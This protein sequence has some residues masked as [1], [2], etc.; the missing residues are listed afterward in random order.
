MKNSPEWLNSRSEQGEE[1]V[2]K[3]E[4][5]STE[6][7]Q[8]EEQNVKRIKTYEQRP[9]GQHKLYQYMH[10]GSSRWGGDRERGRKNIKE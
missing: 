5:R 3:L 6:I 10:N 8:Y 9:V 1:S 2:C 7:R 4:D